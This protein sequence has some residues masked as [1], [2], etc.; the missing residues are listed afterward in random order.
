MSID[1]S[2][3][4]PAASPESPAAAGDDQSNRTGIPDESELTPRGE[5]ELPPMPAARLDDG[6]YAETPRMREDG[7]VLDD[8]GEPVAPDDVEKHVAMAMDPD[9][10]PEPETDPAP[11]GDRPAHPYLHRVRLAFRGG[12]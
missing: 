4:Q 7:V 2:P 11:A 5:G 6:T 1:R 12:S 10:D 9:P 3:A 8:D